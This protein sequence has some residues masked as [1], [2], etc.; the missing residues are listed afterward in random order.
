MNVVKKCG[1][2]NKQNFLTDFWQSTNIFDIMGGFGRCDHMTK[3]PIVLGHVET[4]V[5]SRRSLY[6]LYTNLAEGT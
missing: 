5:H 4:K 2:Q 3:E 1:S 6:V